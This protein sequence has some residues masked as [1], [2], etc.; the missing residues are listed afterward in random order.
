VSVC[1]PDFRWSAISSRSRWISLMLSF[2]GA[3]FKGGPDFSSL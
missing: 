1:A 2:I 3:S